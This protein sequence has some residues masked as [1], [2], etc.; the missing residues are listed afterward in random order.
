MKSTQRNSIR[1]AGMLA[2]LSG[3]VFALSSCS[4][5]S[6][7]GT[8]VVLIVIDTLR[9]DHF[10]DPEQLIDTPNL[11]ALASDGVSFSRAY[12]HAPM[13]LPAHTA[14]FSSQLPDA[15][16]I[17]LNRQQVP[18][19]VPLL[20]EFLKSEGYETSA[21]VSIW[22]L[23]NR[24]GTYG[25]E[26]GFDHYDRNYIGLLPPAPMTQKRMLPEVRRL[27]S[28][29][30]PFFLFAHYSDPHLPYNV[31]DDSVIRNATVKLDGEL[32]AEL[33]ISQMTSWDRQIL[34]PPGTHILDLQSEFPFR[35]DSNLQF[36]DSKIRLLTPQATD[37][38]PGHR[39]S[40]SYR[41]IITRWENTTSSPQTLDV[42][43]WLGE[44]PSH[45]E[46]LA[47]Y[48]GEVEFVDGYVGE[49]LDELKRLQLYDDA[50]II[51]TSDHGE[52]LGE[53]DWWGHNQNLYDELLH[54][55]LVI[56][57]PR[58]NR[59]ADALRTQAEAIVNHID[60][61]PTILD[62]LQLPKLPG[63]T[64]S[65]LLSPQPQTPIAHF[66][67]THLPLT[68]SATAPAELGED[69]VSL[70][71]DRFKLIYTRTQDRF[72]MLDLLADPTELTDV[73]EA[74]GHERSDWQVQ[75]KAAAERL[76]KIDFDSVL[77]GASDAERQSLSALGYADTVENE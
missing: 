1:P 11:D 33:P 39:G 50:L 36:D 75:L 46:K 6:N 3:L 68:E 57:L 14:I 64:G 63:Q 7:A 28:L 74:H 67:A 66:A 72:E 58:H 41:R 59:N 51:F 54:V 23:G 38:V 30:R 71:D 56:K 32:L 69:L 13:T 52:A 20:A 42:A 24:T 26:R 49:L 48:P 37:F 73:F 40:R 9:A 25:I 35:Y 47:R 65:S 70:Q 18:K 55:P 34:L 15:T 21:V 77:N 27:A 5:S 76:G 60:L 53:H 45:A 16:G 61:T 31:H 2:L 29:G 17:V 44:E 22:T 4:D 12:S 8:N 10:I 19:Q 43:L 62:V